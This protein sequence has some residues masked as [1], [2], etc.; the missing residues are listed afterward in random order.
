[1]GSVDW[2][3]LRVSNLRE[4]LTP[5]S[6]SLVIEG[7][8]REVLQELPSDF[9]RC[10]VTSPPYWGTRDYGMWG[11]IGAEMQL[12]DYLDGLAPIFAEVKR[13]LRPDGT[14]W[15][16]IGDVYTSGDRGWRAPDKKHELHS[17]PI[18]RNR[19]T[20][21]RPQLGQVT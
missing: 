12:E 7:D 2:E 16:N 14:L 11:Q 3:A 8:A 17:S 10:C 19:F 18:S 15:L 20:Q 1:M 6:V 4:V 13:V 5:D 21:V 9:F